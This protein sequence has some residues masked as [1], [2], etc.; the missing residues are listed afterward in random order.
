MIEILLKKIDTQ[1]ISK[2]KPF[3]N[4]YKWNDINFPATKKDWNKFEVNNKNI[5]LNILYVPYGNF[6]CRGENTEKY[7]TIKKKIEYIIIY[8]YID[9]WDKFNEKVV[10]N[11]TLIFKCIDCDKEYEKELKN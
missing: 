1:R 2:I 4:T 11:E 3:I 5:A 6:E 10:M 9:E 7:I 8:E